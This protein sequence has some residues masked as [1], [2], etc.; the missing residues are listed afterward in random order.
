[1]TRNLIFAG[2]GGQGIILASKLVANAAL[3]SGLSVRTAETIGMA[4]RGGSVVSHVRIGAGAHSPLP[5]LGSADAIV[6]F[7]PAEAVRC[8]PYLREGG[9]VVVSGVAIAPVTSSLSGSDY[10]GGEMVAYLR[11]KVERVIVVDA[12]AVCAECGSPKVL[13]T[14]LLGAAAAAGALGITL[15]EM[16]STIESVLPQKFVRMNLQALRAGARYVEET[17]P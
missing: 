11:R 2:V 3:R 7:E 10:D 13:N 15:D 6:G 14:A 5:P 17:T 1:M 9:V 12:E 16:A 8:L 4:Q